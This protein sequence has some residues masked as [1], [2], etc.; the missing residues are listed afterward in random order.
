M[1]RLFVFSILILEHF[2]KNET[3]LEI[4]QIR[5]FGG[6]KGKIVILLILW[7]IMENMHIW[8]SLGQLEVKIIEQSIRVEFLA[9]MTILVKTGNVP[10]TW[11]LLV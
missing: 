10:K 2:E 5:Q 11:E 7:W 4:G 9:K 6:F 8:D 3:C 1:G